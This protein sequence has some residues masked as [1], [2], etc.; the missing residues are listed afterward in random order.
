MHGYVD[1][2][3]LFVSAEG[4]LARTPFL[5][6]MAL[7]LLLLVVYEAVFGGQTLQLLTGWLAYPLFIYFGVCLLSKRLHDRGKSGWYA[8][9]IVAAFIAMWPVPQGV[10]DFLFAVVLLWAVVELAI[11]P[12]EQGPNRYGPNPQRPAAVA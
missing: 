6:A 2:K 3:T 7:L 1:L 4:R 9:V 11:L 12:G 10:L 5:V 8:A